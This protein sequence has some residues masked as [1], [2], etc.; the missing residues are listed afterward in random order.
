MFLKFK[1]LKKSFNEYEV[2]ED[3][4]FDVKKGEICGIIGK[5]G[6]GKSTILN[7]FM[8]LM[9]PSSGKILLN[10]KNFIRNFRKNQ[11]IIG[12]ASQENT[13]F[14]ELSIKENAFYFGKTYGLKKKQIIS[15]LDDLLKLLGL[16]GFEDYFIR[17]L[18]GG[19]KK[20]ANLLVALIH[21]PKILV[22]DEPTT[23]LDF[24]LRKSFWEYIKR[25]NKEE[26]LTVI[27]TSH[28]LDEIEENCNRIVIINDKKVVAEGRKQDY[29]KK[30]GSDSKIK[31]VFG[32]ILK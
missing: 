6:C 14:D 1:S 27:V 30:Y 16:K 12:F 26:D 3:I 19:M 4:S 32:E 17:A 5:S 20:R 9:K 25:I 31:D 24:L 21:K 7:I 22:L 23:G 13:L 29:K 15:R 8:G 2:L 28:L 18:S 11:K 10:S